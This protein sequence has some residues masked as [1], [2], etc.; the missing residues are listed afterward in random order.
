MRETHKCEYCEE[1]VKEGFFGDIPLPW[2]QVWDGSKFVYYCPVHWD[3]LNKE[4]CN[5]PIPQP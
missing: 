3:K 1:Q 4:P 5:K 2:G